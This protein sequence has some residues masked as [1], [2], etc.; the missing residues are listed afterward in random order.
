[1]FSKE[2]FAS[3]TQVLPN[4]EELRLFIERIADFLKEF[5]ELFARLK[6]GLTQTFGEY[7]RVY[8]NTDA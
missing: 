3:M 4:N 5:V 8:T 7:K 2:E 1:M 6:D